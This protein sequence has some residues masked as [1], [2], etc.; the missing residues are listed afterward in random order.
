MINFRYRTLRKLGEGGGGEVYL[1]EDVLKERR[2]SAMKILHGESRSDPGADEQFRN[3]VSIL[4]ALRHPNLVRVSD[5][6]MIRHSDDATL[7][8]RRFFTMEYL[9]GPNAGEW[10]R[11]HRG[12]HDGPLQLKHIVLQALG[13]LAYVH[14][15]GI[16][17]FDIKPENL[18][19]ISSGRVDDQFPLLKLT[20]FGF[21]AAQNAALEFPLR[22]TLE[23]TAPELLR[24]EAF[25]NRVD[26][27]S[28]GATVY[29]LI[30][31]RCPFEAGD[32]VELIKKVLTAEP[33][34]HRCEE[35]EYSSMLPLVTNLLQKDPAHRYRSAGIAAQVFL[36]NDKDA[37]ALAVDRLPRPGFVGRE[38]EKEL[39]GSAI[40]P[41]HNG[42]QADPCVA[43]VV[44]GPEGIGKTALLNEMAQVARA[45]DV[46]VFEVTVQEQ[47]PPFGAV[48]SLLPLL[49][50]EA[51]SRSGAGI[52][53]AER[54]AEVVGGESGPED[55]RA[56]EL[57]VNWMRDRDK[58][59]DTLARFL[60]QV[61][62]LFPLI[63]IV[64][65]AHL[66]DPESEE[67]LRIAFRDA[68]PGRLLLLAALRGERKLTVPARHIR[69]E[70]LDA[71]AV[72]A[73]SA[74]T[75]SSAELSE[76]LGI[77]LHQ[78]YGGLP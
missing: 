73:M 57:R 64:D 39:I 65:D 69:L 63:L 68:R 23:Y 19:L 40:A 62:S 75:L 72:S 7:Q 3:E 17:H 60:N 38:K 14:Q 30:E 25:D 9:Q 18:L 13:V 61:S 15:R 24:H 54:F 28:L 31:D 37:A 46:P 29:H 35:E 44:E 41:L 76:L 20:D 67:V 71:R 70:E 5:F 45:T 74:S 33:E 55:A 32:P 53:L 12:E 58:V 77:R 16:I 48:L 8:G 52:E 51:M 56:G 6:G 36:G 26:L 34:F 4:A 78:L 1:V 2:Q 49:R 10:W 59:A 42:P 11:H 22:G 27:Y 43:I 66:L 21:S 50:A 47:D